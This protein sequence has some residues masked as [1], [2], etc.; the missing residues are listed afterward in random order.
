MGASIGAIGTARAQYHLRQ[1]RVFLNV[2]PVNQPAVMIG[3]P[4]QRFDAEDNLTDET[5]KNYMRQ[6]LENLIELI[7]RIRQP[8]T[9]VPISGSRPLFVLR[10]EHHVRSDPH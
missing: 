8:S 5:T 7:Q 2:F 6:L 1:F 9:S 3:T 10:Y 4:A